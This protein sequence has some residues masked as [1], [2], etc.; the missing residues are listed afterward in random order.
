[1][2]VQNKLF[3]SLSDKMSQRQA[4]AHFHSTLV[5]ELSDET[6]RFPPA[7][8]RRSAVGKSFISVKA[9]ALCVCQV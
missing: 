9:A 8:R 7:W 1:M 4:E 2:Q 5:R 3:K 6:Q